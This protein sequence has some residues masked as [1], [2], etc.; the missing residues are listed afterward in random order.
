MKKLNLALM[1][2]ML[3]PFALA[4]CEGNDVK[5]NTN[6]GASTVAPAPTEDSKLL[7]YNIKEF[8][9]TK[10]VPQ[11]PGSSGMGYDENV[12]NAIN[13]LIFDLEAN[14]VPFHSEI[15]PNQVVLA[16]P[17]EGYLIHN[18][19]SDNSVHMNVL[20]K[21]DMSFKEKNENGKQTNI[22][23][24]GGLANPFTTIK[25]IIN[26]NKYNGKSVDIK[27][28][29]VGEALKITIMQDNNL[30]FI[31]KLYESRFY[32]EIYL[33][34]RMIDL[35]GFFEI[36]LERV[37]KFIDEFNSVKGFSLVGEDAHF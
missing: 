21:K 1:L 15:R 7:D 28:S 18:N 6:P 33:S 24:N 19:R 12:K 30:I 14:K 5:P 10:Y 3:A 29:V 37:N 22:Y 34:E 32:T 13:S 27:Y 2:L 8:T 11:I 35:N 26:D 16:M 9:Y 20:R 4:S 17:G 23:Y 31:L 36:E 25:Q